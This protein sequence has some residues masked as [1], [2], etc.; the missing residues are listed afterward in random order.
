MLQF[1]YIK[2]YFTCINTI[3]KII[4]IFCYNIIPQK[5]FAWPLLRFN[6]F[7]MFFMFLC[8]HFHCIFY[9]LHLN[10]NAFQVDQEIIDDFKNVLYFLRVI[11]KC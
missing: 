1:C 11:C 5:C 8:Y 7:E 3:T 4:G 10:K 2:D 9:G 6:I